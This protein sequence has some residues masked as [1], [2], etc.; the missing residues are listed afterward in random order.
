VAAFQ[1]CLAADDVQLQ[2]RKQVQDPALLPRCVIAWCSA[3]M[4]SPQAL[5]T[6]FSLLK[7]VISV[8]SPIAPTVYAEC[9]GAVSLTCPHAHVLCT[10]AVTKAS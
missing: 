1:S 3:L 9:L 4:T 5:D 2:L 8:R 6:F 7:H 10:T